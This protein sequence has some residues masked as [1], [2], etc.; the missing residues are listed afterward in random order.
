MKEFGRELGGLAESTIGMY[1]NNRRTPDNET[2]VKIA[3]Y[4]Q[5][6]VQHLLGQG[7]YDSAKKEFIKEH[8]D[9]VLTAM[10]SDGLN[11]PVEMIK[12]KSFEIQFKLLS[13]FLLDIKVDEENR[14]IQL[15]YYQ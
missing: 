1:E 12:G 4:F 5:V 11:E 8:L 15:V 6:P 3:N 7:L 14:T 2:L 10:E 13:A 9:L